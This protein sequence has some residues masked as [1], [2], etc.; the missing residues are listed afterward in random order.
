M[1]VHGGTAWL[2]AANRGSLV[3][4]RQSFLRSPRFARRLLYVLA[5]SIAA[6]GCGD[7]AVPAQG[8]GA[9]GEVVVVPI[10]AQGAQRDYDTT[11]ISLVLRHDGKA[12][13]LIPIR[14]DRPNPQQVGRAAPV[15][16]GAST[17]W[18]VGSPSIQRSGLQSKLVR[19]DDAG[20]TWQIS[21]DFPRLEEASELGLLVDGSGSGEQ[22]ATVA[23]AS[24]PAFVDPG[25]IVPIAPRVFRGTLTEA[26]TTSWVPI[27]DVASGR[28][29][30]TAIL[31]RHGDHTELLRQF[32]AVVSGRD[33]ADPDTRIEVLDA[34]GAR[35][36]MTI[37]RLFE[38][39]DFDTFGPKGWIAGRRLER[40]GDASGRASIVAF[41]ERHEPLESPLLDV[42][43]IATTVNFASARR[44]F[45]CGVEAG[46][47]GVSGSDRPFCLR[48]EDGGASWTRSELPPDTA[49]VKQVQR[50]TR[51]F[52][53]ALST[54]N[55]GEDQLL[56][57][58]DDGETWA[59]V[60]LPRL[61]ELV[62]FGTMAR[63][64]S[65]SDWEPVAVRPAP[66]A[67]PAPP[68]SLPPGSGP[69]AWT[70]GDSTTLA[71]GI[72]GAVMRSD[73]QGVTWKLIRTEAGATFTDVEFV[74]RD[75]GW[76]LAR[77]HVLRTE[78][79]G[80]TFVD[81]IAALS[82]LGS[83]LRPR[84]ISASD[85][86]TAVMNVAAVFD[87][88]LVFTRDGG[89]TWLRANVEGLTDDLG[90]RFQMCVTS[91]RS[92]IAVRGSDGQVLLTGD[93]GQSWHFGPS[94]EWQIVNG[95]DS[96]GGSGFEAPRLVCSGEMDLRILVS[97]ED[98]RGETLWHSPDGG[99]TWANLT[100]A[101]GV[102]PAALS[103]V[104]AFPRSAPCAGWLAIVREDPLA[105][106]EYSVPL[107]RTH[108]CG[109][110]WSNLSSPLAGRSRSETGNP[111]FPVAIEFLDAR[112]GMMVTNG[113]IA[114]AGD[115]P[116]ITP[117]SIFTT[118]D[119][120]ESWARASLPD[121]FHP[122]DLAFVP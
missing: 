74:D 75:T 109:Q 48:T 72:T 78:D 96:A 94:F 79:G 36:V 33:P 73:D 95:D 18:A 71:P 69:R 85:A 38:A 121:G 120:G 41:D 67:T 39:R 88:V 34:A 16:S 87:D 2:D 44:G 103:P 58:A 15:F 65:A 97:G 4:R 25:R 27:P 105:Q 62:R 82:F 107:V 122:T 84:S 53:W 91:G 29:S 47:P 42:P 89:Q 108:D 115:S 52:G 6:G 46:A 112:T 21:A 119:G 22:S 61:G 51:E 20:L 83:D 35:P 57:T 50:G 7:S 55:L 81:Q 64:S 14:G 77:G 19:S 32:R 43:S 31:R 24:D 102:I 92:G 110:S 40:L 60:W 68:S 28:Y 10:A 56:V 3:E 30:T 80:D 5:F 101:V 116:L 63:N 90:E 106:F 17:L 54:S 23:M 76:A 93:G 26:S 1:G 70:A 8:F 13:E 45:V 98:R 104:G 86:R 11:A 113:R 49:A 12:Y 66:S 111:E 118:R 59:T 114:Y 99:A 37:D 117:P 9:S 100:A